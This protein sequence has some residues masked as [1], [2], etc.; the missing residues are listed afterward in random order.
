MNVP[1]NL[2]Y[3]STDE[4]VLVEGKT[5]TIGI[6]DYAQSQLSD[7]VYVEIRVNPGEKLAKNAAVASVESVKAASDVNAPVSGKVVASNEGLAQTPEVVNSDP[8]GAAWMVKVE[9]STPAELD[10][11]MDA[12]AYEAYCG[13]ERGH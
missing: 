12:A 5:A 11:L 1:K 9:L 8:Y 3:S 13:E 7:I 2:K 10:S 4:W 6:T